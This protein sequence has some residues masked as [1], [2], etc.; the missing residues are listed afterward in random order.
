MSRGCGELQR[1]LLDYMVNSK[2]PVTYAEIIAALLQ[3]EGVNDPTI[4]LRPDRE[5]A[6]R[7]A[8]KGLCDRDMLSTLGTGRPGNP[9]RYTMSP[10]CV[11]CVGSPIW[12][13]RNNLL[14][15]RRRSCTSIF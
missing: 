6:F 14:Q 9:Y 7:R 12:E 13:I 1:T 8:L 4:K 5:R 10:I 11:F 15:V 2:K 3:A